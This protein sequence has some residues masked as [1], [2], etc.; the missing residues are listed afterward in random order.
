MKLVQLDGFFLYV[1]KIFSIENCKFSLFKMVPA[2][3]FA[4]GTWQVQRKRWK[5]NLIAELNSRTSADPVELPKSLEEI[6]R[7][8]YRPVRVRGHFLH[9]Q[10]L[11]MGPRTL[12]KNGKSATESTL[13][14]GK[15]M[16]S[17]GYLVVTPFKLADRE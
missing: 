11:Y 14:S 12:L 7:L 3:T 6:E 9:D 8:E 4:L 17:Q 13:I 2:S 1:N 16:H 15:A 5:E 10:E